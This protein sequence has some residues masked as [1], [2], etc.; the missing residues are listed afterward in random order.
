MPQ[1]TKTKAKSKAASKPT[2]DADAGK[3]AIALLEA[4]HREVRALFEEFEQATG[5]ADK[6]RLAIAICTALKVHARLEEDIFY[7]AAFAAIEDAD[8][9]GEA[10]VE[11]ASARDLIAQIES[12]APGEALY[13]AR[14]RV[15]SEY[16]DHHVAEE[17]GE[18]FPQCRA[19]G[20]DLD[21]LGQL[22]A[23]RKHE[24]SVGFTVSNPILALS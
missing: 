13:D 5:D 10:Q 4:D 21:A 20:L 9:I 6:R 2:S 12:G 22:L 23:V 3:D 19:S 11:H 15:L 24:L 14:V 18:I 16:I 17:E 7:P 8:L 1:P